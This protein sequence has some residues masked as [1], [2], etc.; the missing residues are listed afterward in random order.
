MYFTNTL[1][2]NI[3]RRFGGSGLGTFNPLQVS[4]I[5]AWLDASDVSTI[6]EVSNR[7]SVWGNKADPTNDFIQNT[8][9][10]RPTTNQGTLNQ[11]NALQFGTSDF[12][13]ATTEIPIVRSAMF[14]T[15]NLLANVAVHAIF[16]QAY[17][18]PDPS[19]FVFLR[20]AQPDYD[21]S[22]DGTDTTAGNASVNGGDLV[23]GRNIDLGLTGNEVDVDNIWYC[24]FDKDVKTA[25]VG[26]LQFS[27][28]GIIFMDGQICELCLFDRIITEDERRKMEGYFAYKWGTVAK[29]PVDHPYKN[30][31]RLFGFSMLDFRD[32]PNSQY[33]P[34]F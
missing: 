30:D 19:N 11:L 20:T 6:T 13:E 32:I 3:I 21:I 27:V 24:D 16:G 15:N 17:V 23:A 22:I 18:D 34:T 31:G 12:M 1:M 25:T 9:D 2:G 29:L 5:K 28:G 33:V 7:V 8:N 14:V 26:K 4:G 10:D